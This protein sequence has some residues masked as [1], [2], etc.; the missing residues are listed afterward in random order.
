MDIAKPPWRAS[1]GRGVANAV[2]GDLAEKIT[3]YQ[4]LGWAA[5]MLSLGQGQTCNAAIHHIT[6]WHCGRVAA[7]GTC[8]TAQGLAYRMVLFGRD[9]SST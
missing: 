5:K 8:P 2:S 1:G 4:V 7:I 3:L 6:W 9:S